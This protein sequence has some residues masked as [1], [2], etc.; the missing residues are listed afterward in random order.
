MNYSEDGTAKTSLQNVFSLSILHGPVVSISHCITPEDQH[1]TKVFFYKGKGHECNGFELGYDSKKDP[2]E[3]AHKNFGF[4]YLLM[5]MWGLCVSIDPQHLSQFIWNLKPTEEVVVYNFFT[6]EEKAFPLVIESDGF[7]CFQKS[8]ELLEEDG[9]K[10]V[11][12]IG[13]M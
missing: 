13:E 1:M 5:S 9:I 6:H 7:E 10:L 8:N 2:K 11:D 4:L 3:K 12:V